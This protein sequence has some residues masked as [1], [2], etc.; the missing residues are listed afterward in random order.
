[1]FGADRRFLISLFD[2]AVKAADPEAA[3]AAYLPEAPKGRTVVVGAGKAA[4]KMA[5]AFEKLWDKPLEGVVVDRH[6]M[7]AETRKVK[8]IQA[9][10]PVPDEAG[11]A[12]SAALFEALEGLTEDDLVV[13]LISGGASSLL[14]CPAGNLSLADEIAVNRALL[15]SGAP[16]TAMNVV[17]K[18][19]SDIKGGKLA[20]A[21]SPAPVVS[22][23]VSDVVEDDPAIIGSGPTVPSH[24]SA[25]DALAIVD[26]YDLK[27]PASVIEHLTKENAERGPTDPVFSNHAA[28]VIASARVSLEAA[29]NVAQAQGIKPVILSDSI[30]GEAREVGKVFAA[31]AGEI[32]RWNRPFERPV[33]LL[34]GGETTVT[35]GDSKCG[36]GGRNSE[37]LLSFACGIENCQNIAAL[38]ADTDGIDGSETNAGAFADGE[39]M[40]RIRKAGGNGEAFLANHDSWSAFSLIGDLFEPGATGTN[41]NDFRAILVR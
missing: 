17:R 18:H 32:S 31:L 30:E 14:P 24:G 2:A 4:S 21:A 13:A 20:L 7:S 28:L 37:F 19:I 41:V 22:L 9:S 35:I 36:K 40:A 12:A 1:M 6:G 26:D 15:A 10:H 8:V 11:I 5:L 38:A 25:R 33:V 3:I 27:L 29:A 23:I 39:T 16:I 34:S